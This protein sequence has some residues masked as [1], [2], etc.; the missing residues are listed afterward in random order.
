MKW[1]LKWSTS[2]DW[3]EWHTDIDDVHLKIYALEET[4]KQCKAVYERQAVKKQVA[5]EWE[6]REVVEDVLV[7]YDCGESTEA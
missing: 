4:P 3:W 6:E 5:I 1:E 2:C 7:G